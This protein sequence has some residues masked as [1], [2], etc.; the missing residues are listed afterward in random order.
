MFNRLLVTLVA[1][2]MLTSLLV[3]LFTVSG[4]HISFFSMMLLAF[5]I[6]P[7]NALLPTTLSGIV[8]Y[9]QVKR[10]RRKSVTRKHQVRIAVRLILICEAIFTVWAL[11]YLLISGHFHGFWTYYKR[12]FIGWNL[13]LLL[14]GLLIPLLFFHKRLFI[15]FRLKLPWTS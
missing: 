3:T 13:I 2:L 4:E 15:P 11:A 12:N 10:I 6:I 9:R 1:A 8:F 7:L 5:V 14:N